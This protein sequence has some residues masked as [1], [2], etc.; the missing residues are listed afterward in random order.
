MDRLGLFS[1]IASRQALEDAALELD[2]ENRTRVGAILG[3][4][5]GPMESMEEFSVGVIEEGA[6]GANPAVFPNT[7]YNAAGGQVAIKVGTLGSASTVTVGH[8]AGAASLCYGYD[9]AA[10]DHADGVVCLGADSLTETVITAYRGLGVLEGMALAEAGVAVLVERLGRAK[11]RG[12]RIRGEMLGYAITSDARG[13]GRVDGDGEGLERAMRLALERSGVSAGD[14]AAVWAARCGL[15]SADA[16]ESAAI[17]RVLGADVK[18]NAPKLLLGEP[19][20]AGPSLS[21]ALAIAA[22]DHGTDVGP[23]LVNGTSLGGTNVAIVLAP[24]MD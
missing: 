16:A 11:D 7:V 15:A 24:Y 1:I 6:G 14:V 17:E 22:W 13:I 23:V 2:D 19:M 20:G 10:T 8:A 5:V 4:G 18:V 3:T 21:V 9:L 12:A